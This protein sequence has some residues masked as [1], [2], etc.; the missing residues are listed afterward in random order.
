MA[1][2]APQLPTATA[3][4]RRTPTA[5]PSY[6]AAGQTFRSIT[7]K[8]SAHRPEPADRHGLVRLLRPQ[9]CCCCCSSWPSSS[10]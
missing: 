7:D 1:T 10:T 9:H 8:I 2:D 3:G 4:T 6:I 5:E